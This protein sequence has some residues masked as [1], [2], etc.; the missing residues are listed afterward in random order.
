MNAPYSPLA[1]TCVTSN[2]EREDNKSPFAPRSGSWLAG[3]LS[4]RKRHW[5]VPKK[6]TP[7]DPCESGWPAKFSEELRAF[8][9]VGTPLSVA[10]TSSQDLWMRFH[11]CGVFPTSMSLMLPRS[12]LVQAD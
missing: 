3:M 6:S 4:G 8:L 11:N 7:A 12:Y 10:R 1:L 5:N 9:D 2:L